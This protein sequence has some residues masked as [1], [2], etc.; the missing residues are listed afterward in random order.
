MGIC[1]RGGTAGTMGVCFWNL[2]KKIQGPNATTWAEKQ[3]CE[4]K[5]REQRYRFFPL[6][7]I[8]PLVAQ[9]GLAMT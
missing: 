4:V 2:L 1:H 8:L 5:L 3:H 9:S 7:V 6:V